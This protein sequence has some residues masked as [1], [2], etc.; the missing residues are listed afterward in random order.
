MVTINLRNEPFLNL[1]DGFAKTL[2]RTPRTKNTNPLTGEE[3]FSDGTPVSIRGPFFRSEDSYSQE[4]AGI[5]KDADGVLMVRGDVTINRDD[6]ITYE[7]EDYRVHEVEVR[8]L[9]TITFY[10]LVRLYKIS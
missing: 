6:K 4:Q 5:L 8:R 2:T 7:S 9:G 1:L 3:D 10:K